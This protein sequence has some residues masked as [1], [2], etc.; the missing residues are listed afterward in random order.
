MFLRYQYTNFAV[1]CFNL[2][3][4]QIHFGRTIGHFSSAN[5]ETGVMPRAL[6]VESV[7]AAFGERT[8][9]MGAKFLKSVKLIADP[10]DCHHQL[11]DFDARCF[12]IAQMF[13]ARNGNKDGLSTLGSVSG[14]KMKRVLR[15]WRV[16]F[17]AADA[18]SFVV[19]K[20]ATQVTGDGQKA[21]AD[22]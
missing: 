16:M 21:E 5:V 7:E 6:H 13:G 12:A 18:D 8:K 9:A 14:R 17:V 2:K 22:D 20:T 10:R 3:C 11:V 15:S 1:A 4:F 19:H